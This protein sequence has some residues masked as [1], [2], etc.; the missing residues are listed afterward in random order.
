MTTSAEPTLGNF[1]VFATIGG[2]VAFSVLFCWVLAGMPSIPLPSLP[3]VPAWGWIVSGAWM[4][5]S[6]L[7]GWLASQ[8][9]RSVA[10]WL[11][12]GLLLGPFALVAVGMAPARIR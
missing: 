6:A 9:G 2:V 11:A 1:S 12:L 7:S 8:R 5:V 3:D 10:A 4:G